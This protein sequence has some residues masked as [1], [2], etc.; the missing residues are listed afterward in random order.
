MDRS[1]SSISLSPSGLLWPGT[2]GWAGTGAA[3]QGKVATSAHEEFIAS[4]AW[5]CRVVVSSALCTEP[6]DGNPSCL[7][8]QLPLEVEW[9]NPA[10]ATE[11]SPGTEQTFGLRARNVP[12]ATKV[13]LFTG[14]ELS[15]LKPAQNIHLRYQESRP[16]ETLTWSRALQQGT[17]D[18]LSKLRRRKESSPH[19]EWRT[20]GIN[21]Q[22]DF[23]SFNISFF[24][25]KGAFTCWRDLVEILIAKE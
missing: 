24:I 18:V 4:A 8:A 15:G 6:R 11:A 21:P 20:K 19:T 2:V 5:G 12:H 1:S 7:L 16:A 17:A 22:L 9:G 23:F 10:W 14:W 25:P 13:I 3:S